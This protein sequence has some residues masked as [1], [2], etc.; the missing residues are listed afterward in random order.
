[1]LLAP[2]NLNGL[3]VSCLHKH[4]GIRH[5]RMELNSAAHMR[6]DI[7]NSTLHAT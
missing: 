5:V 1:M 7:F 6:M 2:K 3:P 4:Y